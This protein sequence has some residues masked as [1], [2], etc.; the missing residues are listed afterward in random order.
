MQMLACQHCQRNVADIPCICFPV[1][2]RGS[3]FCLVLLHGQCLL[4]IT[5]FTLGPL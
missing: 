5:K 3:F 4:I 2:V 1:V